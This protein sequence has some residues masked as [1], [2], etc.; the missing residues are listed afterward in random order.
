MSYISIYY[1]KLLP[2]KN[3]Q[4]GNGQSGLMVNVQPH[5]DMEHN[6]DFEC[7]LLALHWIVI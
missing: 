6:L 7:A 5:V 2:D 4:Q 3:G 1:N